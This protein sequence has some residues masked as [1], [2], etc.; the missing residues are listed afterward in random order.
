VT[1][2]ST[3][4]PL[5]GS[6]VEL[7]P[8]DTS[9]AAGLAAASAVGRDT[10][11]FTEVPDGEDAMRDYI[12]R[13]LQQRDAGVSVP[14]AQRLVSSG[15]LIGCTRYLDIRN[16]RGRPEPDEV[17]I[18]GTWLAADVQRS[19]ANTESKLLMLTNAFETWGVF[20]VAL[21]TDERNERSRT[22][23]EG[24]GAR[25]EGILRNSRPSTHPGE[26]GRPRRT[27]LFSITDE[28]W[29]QVKARL[30]ARL[31]RT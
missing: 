7:I 22:A 1:L 6:I 9:L 26:E 18:G 27:A 29:P 15:R 12:R 8:L 3:T 30:I 25:F 17:E 11:G 20:R 19:G 23:I 13:V 28:E 16:W 4:G 10:Y 2:A 21:A 31:A 24:I 5:T 14:F